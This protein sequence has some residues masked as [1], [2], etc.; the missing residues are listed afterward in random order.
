MRIQILILGFKELK[1]PVFN[2]KPYSDLKLTVLLFTIYCFFADG[3]VMLP[4]TPRNRMRQKRTPSPRDSL[5]QYI[6]FCR[7]F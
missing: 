7:S 6:P 3:H 2:T 1:K 4:R 5:C